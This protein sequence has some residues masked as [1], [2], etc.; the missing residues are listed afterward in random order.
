MLDLNMLF[1]LMMIP[2]LVVFVSL[3]ILSFVSICFLSTEKHMVKFN[4][5]KKSQLSVFFDH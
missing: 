2:V 5:F 1:T 4:F 3:F